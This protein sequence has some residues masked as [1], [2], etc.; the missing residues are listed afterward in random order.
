MPIPI[1]IKVYPNPISTTQYTVTVEPSA[2]IL[3]AIASYTSPTCTIGAYDP[4]NLTFPFMRLAF[5]FFFGAEYA[6]II[7][8][9][10]TNAGSTLYELGDRTY[11]DISYIDTF[12]KD[13][14]GNTSQYVRGDGSLHTFPSI[15]AAPVNPDWNAVSGLAQILNKP[16]IPAAQVQADWSASTGLA[17]IL[18]KPQMASVA[19][20]TGSTT[21][22]VVDVLGVQVATGAAIT[23]LGATM[24]EMKTKFNAF[25]TNA[26]ASSLMAA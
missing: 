11:I 8:T 19:V 2:M 16:A 9:L 5:D 15:P 13:P 6:N 10:N 7:N 23:T 12:Y 25:I 14:I 24:S 21:T 20:V 17:Q 22:S 26:K 18:N 1:D 3:N 4:G